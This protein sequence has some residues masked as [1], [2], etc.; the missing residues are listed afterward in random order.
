MQPFTGDPQMTC[1]EK[2]CNSHKKNS[3][4]LYQKESDTGVSMFCI[5]S[6]RTYNFEMVKEGCL[7]I[8]KVFNLFQH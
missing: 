8:L 6:L 5:F 3:L 1:F 7:A 2:V 4:Q